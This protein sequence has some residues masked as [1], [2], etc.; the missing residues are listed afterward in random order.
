MI[1]QVLT[2]RITPVIWPWPCIRYKAIWRFEKS[3]WVQ[4]IRPWP[5]ISSKATSSVIRPSDGNLWP[6]SEYKAMALQLATN[7]I[8][9]NAKWPCTGNKAK[10]LLT[11]V[12]RYLFYF[13][14]IFTGTAYIYNYILN[15][16]GQLFIFLLLPLFL[17][18]AFSCVYLDLVGPFQLNSRLLALVFD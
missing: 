4:F 8:F 12:I 2:H 13:T 9:Q 16:Q 10:S 18:V 6:Y 1:N 11:G 14:H 3:S 5:C 17:P 7:S 15:I